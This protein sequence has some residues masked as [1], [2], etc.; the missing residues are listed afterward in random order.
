M[1]KHKDI[2]NLDEFFKHGLEDPVDE[3]VF[4][5]DDWDSLDQMLGKKRTGIVFWLPYLSSAAAIVLIFFGWMLLKPKSNNDKNNTQVVINKTHDQKS[6]NTN[7]TGIKSQ[8]NVASTTTANEVKKKNNLNATGAKQ[9]Q[10]IVSA[11]VK[12]KNTLGTTDK[13]HAKQLFEKNRL[14]NKQ[15]IALN[16]LKDKNTLGT[17]DKL[18]GNHQHE[19]GQFN[20]KQTVASTQIK[21]KNTLGTA[22]KLNTNGTLTQGIAPGFTTGR[23]MLAA[24]NNEAVSITQI[25]EGK[26]TPQSANLLSEHAGAANSANTK[27]EKGLSTKKPLGFRPQYALSVLASQELN[28]VGSLQQA[29]GGYNIGLLFKAQLVKKFSITTGANYSVKPYSLPF[30][31]YHTAYQF[32]NAPESVSADCRILDIPINIDYQLYN[33]GRN[34]FSVGTGLSSY[35]ML[36]ESYTYD[37]GSSGTLYGPSYYAVK[38]R[39]KYFFSIMNLEA[40]YERKINSKVGISLQPYLKMPLSNIGYS[41][42]RIETFG[43]AV[44]LN[45]NINSLTKPK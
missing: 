18:Q 9:E 12:D 45:W 2:K 15:A 14:R 35:I 30:S 40:S 5:E 13:D 17:A 26:F 32:K 23:D 7:R 20:N 28:G 27:G 31:E 37:Y 6:D 43:M 25:N 33:K 36:H 4:Q 1:K 21:D 38:N 16:K 42:V 11:Q 39:G 24:A 22:D 41:Q 44:G 19:L 3:I 34:K 10:V 29:T 8:Q